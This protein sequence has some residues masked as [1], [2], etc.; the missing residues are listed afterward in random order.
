MKVTVDVTKCEECPY[1][2]AGMGWADDSC[3]KVGKCIT[4][5]GIPSFCPFVEPKK[6]LVAGHNHCTSA[7]DNSWKDNPDRMGGQFT[8]EEIARSKGEQW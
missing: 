1:H 6:V 8:D 7:R 5:V 3:T 2:R 4:T